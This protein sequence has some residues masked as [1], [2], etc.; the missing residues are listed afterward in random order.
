MATIVLS[1]VTPILV[2]L[3][4]TDAGF[5][6]LKWLPVIFPALA[7]IVTS[8]STSFPFQENAVSANSAVELLEAELEKF[9]LGVTQSYRWSHLTSDP[10]RRIKQQEAVENFITQVNRIHLKQLQSSE[11]EVQ[12]KVPE[13][14][15]A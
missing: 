3:D 14:V 6:G 4:K 2:L 12:E 10:D 9:V 11:S 7:S 1:G 13:A 15:E 8:V 5:P